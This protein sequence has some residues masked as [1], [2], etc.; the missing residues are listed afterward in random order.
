MTARRRLLGPLLAVPLVLGLGAAPAGSAVSP[1][2]SPTGSPT[3]SPAAADEVQPRVLAISVDGLKPAALHRLGW[4]GTPT[5]HRLVNEGAATLNARTARERTDTL[6]NHTTMVTG[7][8]I[9]RDRGGHG[10]T[11]NDERPGSTVQQAAGEPVWSIYTRVRKSGGSGA[12][13]AGK[14]KFRTFKRSW[15][16]GIDRFV[17]DTDALSLVKKTRSDL[18]KTDRDFTFL[19]LALPDAAGHAHGWMSQEYL[20][21]VRRSDRLLGKLLRAI[22]NSPELTEELTIVL[23]ADHGGRNSGH[24]DATRY[25]NYRIPFLAW[26]RA[27]TAGGLYAMNEEHYRNPKKTR[28]SYAGKQPVRNGDLANLSLDLLGL[29]P[30]PKSTINTQQRLSVS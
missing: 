30:L 18:K 27:V 8:R 21:E 3:G 4:S 22:D 14:D 12:M 15:R 16:Q 24:Y 25:A 1:P 26:G 20:D 13:F 2:V 23:T 7:R 29:D 11:W 9:D 6:P 28:T 10:V 5:L 19:H 17:L